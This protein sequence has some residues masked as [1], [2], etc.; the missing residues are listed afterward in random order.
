MYQKTNNGDKNLTTPSGEWVKECFVDN[1]NTLTPEPEMGY[2]HDSYS[3]RSWMW[4]GMF[5]LLLMVLLVAWMV[6]NK[7]SNK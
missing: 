7:K 4:A 6:Y 2:I 1:G 3:N 5:L